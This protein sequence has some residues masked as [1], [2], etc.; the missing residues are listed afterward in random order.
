MCDIRNAKDN[1]RYVSPEAKNLKK[2]KNKRTS[3]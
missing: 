3:I 1:E 2:K